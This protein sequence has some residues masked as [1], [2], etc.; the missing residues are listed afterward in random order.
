MARRW[1]RG[2]ERSRGSNRVTHPRDEGTRKGRVR[3]GTDIRRKHA[4]KDKREEK[5]REKKRGEEKRREAEKRE[6]KRREGTCG[7]GGSLRQACF[8]T[9]RRRR[10]FIIAFLI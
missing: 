7:P 2:E 10:F 1:P 9:K 6:E 5:R 8:S 3:E 4:E